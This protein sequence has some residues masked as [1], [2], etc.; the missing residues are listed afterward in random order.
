MPLSQ[1]GFR[2]AS[3]NRLGSLRTFQNFTITNKFPHCYYEIKMDLLC[4]INW[5]FI[6]IWIIDIQGLHWMDEVVDWI[7]MMWI[8]TGLKTSNI[9]E[10]F[11]ILQP[12]YI[13][14]GLHRF[15]VARS[16]LQLLRPHCWC[17]GLHYVTLWFPLWFAT[18]T[19]WALLVTPTSSREQDV[20]LAQSP[21]MYPVWL[22]YFN[23]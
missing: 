11:K 4:T 20:H 17:A 19:D 14:N 13:Q 18:V 6:G 8:S 3:L 9:T 5:K 22:P 1:F 21:Q 10:L 2:S 7:D 12:A 16:L 15:T 23:T